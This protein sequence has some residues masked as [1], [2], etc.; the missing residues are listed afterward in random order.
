MG[1]LIFISYPQR[2]IELDSDARHHVF[3]AG[4]IGVTAILG[5]LQ[6]LT[7]HDSAEVHYC[8][9]DND[10]A[11]YLTEL[12]NFAHPVHVHDSFRG[13]RLD[14]AE[15]IGSLPPSATIYSCGPA[16]LRTAVNGA[17]EGWLVGAEL[18]RHGLA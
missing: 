17:T 1:D 6:G 13:G 18:G 9:R 3:I 14:V 12:H 11:P 5:L 2:G 4:G 10:H 16:P 8:V 15:L 7:G